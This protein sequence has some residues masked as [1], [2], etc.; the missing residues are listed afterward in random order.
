MRGAAFGK[1]RMIMKI[2]GSSLRR[3]KRAPDQSE[4]KAKQSQGQ[5]RCGAGPAT[6]RRT[7]VDLSVP[8]FPLPGAARRCHRSDSAPMGKTQMSA[9]FTG[10]ECHAWFG[11]SRTTTAAVGQQPNPLNEREVEE[12]AMPGQAACARALPSALWQLT[13][14]NCQLPPASPQSSFDRLESAHVFAEPTLRENIAAGNRKGTRLCAEAVEGESSL[15]MAE[16]N[17]E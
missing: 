8:S 17:C 1:R 7:F 6:P 11:E 2:F 13:L 10:A 16:E 4:E 3:R 5:K 14:E 9:T 12:A 15:W